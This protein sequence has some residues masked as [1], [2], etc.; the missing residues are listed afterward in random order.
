MTRTNRYRLKQLG[1]LSL[2]ALTTLT[3]L[4]AF[5]Q[6]DAE[7][8]VMVSNGQRPESVVSQLDQDGDIPTSTFQ[9]P[10]ESNTGPDIAPSQEHLL[11]SVS[12]PLFNWMDNGK[13]W[14]NYLAVNMASI[15]FNRGV[16]AEYHYKEFNPGIG[17]ERSNGDYGVAI[18]G[19][20]NSLGVESKY[21]LFIATPAHLAVGSGSN[22]V[23]FSA[24]GAVGGITGYVKRSTYTQSYRQVIPGESPQIVQRTRQVSTTS[25]RPI[26]PAVGAVLTAEWGLWRL[27]AFL[28]PSVHS[29][30]VDGF[31]GFQ[32]ERGF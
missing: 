21:V 23:V 9:A 14:R 10:A 25:P 3:A 12:S 31:S 15:H 13:P 28:V 32:L 19:Y 8:N 16:R 4:P 27:R 20:R 17:Y 26:I 6:S 1:A 7:R 18:G 30:D 2:V 29:L 5:A 24:G 22:Q 11:G